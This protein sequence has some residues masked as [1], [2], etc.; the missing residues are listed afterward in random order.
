MKN[1]FP[2]LLKDPWDV[3]QAVEYRVRVVQVRGGRWQGE[4]T[5]YD[6]IS[7]RECFEEYGLKLAPGSLPGAGGYS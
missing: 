7:D 5:R 3:E 6:H 1:T 2:G 4:L